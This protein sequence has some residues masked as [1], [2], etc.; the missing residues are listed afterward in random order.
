[1]KK[2]HENRI[3]CSDMTKDFLISGEQIEQLNNMGSKK[4]RQNPGNVFHL[5]RG[6]RV[7]PSC[8]ITLCE[9]CIQ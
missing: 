3:T 9:G 4:P 2:F 6:V 1:M 5:P 8:I 7:M